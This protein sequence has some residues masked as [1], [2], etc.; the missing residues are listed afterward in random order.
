MVPAA[1]VF[2]GLILFVGAV[3]R[4]RMSSDGHGQCIAG[5]IPILNG[6]E[7]RVELRWVL[8]MGL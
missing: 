7:L 8:M 3:E 5:L 4:D 2:A 6:C 1:V